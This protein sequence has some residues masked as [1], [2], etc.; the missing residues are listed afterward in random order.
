LFLPLG[1]KLIKKYQLLGYKVGIWVIKIEVPILN[2][3]QTNK[4]VF[5][6]HITTKMLRLKK[7][8]FTNE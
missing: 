6:R 5:N 4:I 2:S 1:I 8:N 3:Y 7:D